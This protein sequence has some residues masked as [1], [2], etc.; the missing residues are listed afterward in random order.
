MT[1]GLFR[2][3]WSRLPV[4]PRPNGSTLVLSHNQRVPTMK[5]LLASLMAALGLGF[6]VGLLASPIIELKDGSRIQGEIQ[7][8]QNGDYT[9]VSPSI[10]TVHI[11]Q[12]NIV[13]ITY[14]GSGE[15]P[16]PAATDTS[17]N[18]Q[19]STEAQQL[20]AQLV[21]DPEAMK[22]ILSLQADPQIQALL[23]DPQIMQAIA[24]GDYASLLA[25]PKIQALDN[26][27][28]LKKVLR[29]LEQ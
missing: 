11:T 2:E 22:S 26:D 19:R 7:S 24:R 27:P 17:G 28:Q 13:R 9:I 29:D 21:Q 4:Q 12:S 20:Q 1:H 14:D 25:N 8:I 6:T 18:D 5:S 3:S 23:N 15:T 16:D 10:G